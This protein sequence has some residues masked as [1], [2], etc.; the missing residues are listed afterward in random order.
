M[1]PGTSESPQRRPVTWEEFVA[2]PDDDRRELVDGVL[3]ETEM[4]TKQHEAVVAALIAHLYFWGLRNGA[5]VVG[6]GY[7]VRVNQRRGVMP[8]V[9]LYRKGN[10]PKRDAVA[11]DEGRP[12]LVVEV[13]SPSTK[14]FDRLTKLEWYASIGVPE[15]WIV[16]L[17]AQLVERLVLRDGHY[18]VEGSAGAE[19]SFRPASFE[20]LEIP[21]VELWK[22]PEGT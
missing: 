18:S 13:I 16:D 6:S 15:Y 4:P 10:H 14:R 3:T 17:D 19:D 21:L 1:Q 7:K 20:G 9:Q 12:D 22:E 2:L 8:D 5:V 11:Q